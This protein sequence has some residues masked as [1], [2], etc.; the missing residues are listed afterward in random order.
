MRINLSVGNAAENK[1]VEKLIQQI[2]DGNDREKFSEIVRL[3]QNRLFSLAMMLVRSEEDA[4]DIVADTFV[5]AY[6]NLK[7]FRRQSQFF[8]YLYRICKNFCWEYFRQQKKLPRFS[9]DDSSAGDDSDRTVTRLDQLTAE[10]RQQ[11]NYIKE[12]V[13]RA[14]RTLPRYFRQTIILKEIYGFKYQEIAAI[15]NCSPM[16]VL[17]RLHRARKLLRKELGASFQNSL[18]EKNILIKPAVLDETKI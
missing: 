17:T 11:Q 7:K 14:I 9:L 12:I 1:E 4:R 16:T 10:D 2:V 8:T 5:A 6:Q 3:Y 15:L 13:W 18:S